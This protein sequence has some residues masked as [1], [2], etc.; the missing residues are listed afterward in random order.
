[1]GGAV[2]VTFLDEP[3]ES[4]DEASSEKVVELCNKFADSDNT[5][6]ITHNPSVKE[7]IGNRL[8]I[9]KKNGQAFL[10]A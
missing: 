8:T 9:E 7:L 6:L 10:N 4:L 1:M 3:F 5:F 2:N